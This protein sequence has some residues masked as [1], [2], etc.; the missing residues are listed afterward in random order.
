MLDEARTGLS[1]TLVIRGEAGIGKTSLLEH[2]VAHADDF[3]VVRLTGLESEQE[4]GYAALHRL[5]SPILHQV[6]SLPEPQRDALNTA[7]GLASGP[8]ADRFLVGLGTISLAANAARA[9]QRLLCIVDDAQWIDRQSLEALA[10]WGRRIV[11]EGIV[12][13]F[14]ERDDA[15][16][17][18]LEGFKVL[19]VHGLRIVNTFEEPVPTRQLLA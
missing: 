7:L 11:A 3:V 15:D 18:P 10:F 6:A 1:S 2:A 8:P 12:L 13:L 5:L 14:S 19:E 17:R 4:I 16:S 9:V